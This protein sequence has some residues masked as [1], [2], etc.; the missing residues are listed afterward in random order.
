M[1]TYLDCLPCFLRQAL[2]AA[3]LAGADEQL[4]KK[5]VD[6]VARQLPRLDLGT[7]PPEMGEVVYGMVGQLTGKRDP[8]RELK[9]RSN[10]RALRLYPRLKRRVAR[11]K[12]RLRQ[13]VELAALG[14][15]I[16]YGVKG[17]LDIEQEAARLLSG[18]LAS[19]TL[20]A[21]FAYR[22]LRTALKKARRVLYLADNAGEIVFDRLLIEELGKEVTLV[23]RGAP[24]INDALYEDALACG[25]HNCARIVD[26]GSKLPGTVLK[27]CSADFRS[28]FRAAELIISK[29][30]G[31]YESLAGEKGNSFFLFR[32]KCAVVAKHVG[33]AEG[34]ILLLDN[35]KQRTR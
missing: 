9:R 3:R 23:V 6:E 13:A 5:I 17:S 29:G 26:N 19:P 7:S 2:G 4:Q 33:C 16:D 31:N 25:L 20:K 27:R 10:R 35:C 14:N 24:V 22:R 1:R 21:N 34:E 30:Q 8:F 15:I 32:A 12:D 11:A 18:R 28:L